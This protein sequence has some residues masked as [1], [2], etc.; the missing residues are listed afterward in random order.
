MKKGMSSFQNMGHP[1]FD[2]LANKKIE[3]E[4]AAINT[5]GREQ[6]LVHLKI[7]QAADKLDICH[8]KAY[9]IER[10]AI[11]SSNNWKSRDCLDISNQAMKIAP[12]DTKLGCVIAETITSHLCHFGE[13]E[14]FEHFLS[15]NGARLIRI[16]KYTMFENDLRKKP[17][18]D[19]VRY[20][21]DV[22]QEMNKTGKHCSQYKATTMVRRKNISPYMDWIVCFWCSTAISCIENHY[23]FS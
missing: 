14:E 11:W 6:G 18:L 23:F 13:L 10:F 2:T 3:Q 15:H 4:N 9:V 16:I 12:L 17:V 8:L 7:L 21:N 1:I 5:A 22:V 19:Q 20:L